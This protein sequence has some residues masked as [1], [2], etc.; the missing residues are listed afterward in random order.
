MQASLKQYIP[1]EPLGSEPLTSSH[2]LSESRLPHHALDTAGNHGNHDENTYYHTK[3]TK[4]TK[5]AFGMRNLA[6]PQF[7]SLRAIFSMPVEGRSPCRTQSASAASVQVS[8]STERMSVASAAKF[9]H[10]AHLASEQMDRLQKENEHL[11]AQLKRTGLVH[12]HLCTLLLH[13]LQ[14][15]PNIEQQTLRTLCEQKLRLNG[16]GVQVNRGTRRRE[17]GSRLVER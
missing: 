10:A 2:P 16:S 5:N 4:S 9:K 17:A 15:E 11:Q 3:G 8:R 12:D 1:V 6:C 7:N 13:E 14:D